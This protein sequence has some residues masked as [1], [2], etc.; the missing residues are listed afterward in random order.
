MNETSVTF[1]ELKEVFRKN[2]ARIVKAAFFSGLLVLFLSFLKEPVY[3]AT[4]TFKQAISLRAQNAS[5]VQSF[6]HEFE[7]KGEEP[8]AVPLM[9]SRRLIGPLVEEMGFQMKVVDSPFENYLC[10]M[11]RNIK[12]ELNCFL[13]DK[14]RFIFRNV[15]Y[16][17]ARKCILYLH[18]NDANSFEVLDAQEAFIATG[19]LNEAL[20]LPSVSFTLEKVPSTLSF[21]QNYRVVISPWLKVVDQLI[22]NISISPHKAD[23]KVLLLSYK[24][25][26]RYLAADLLNRIMA[27]YKMLLQRDNEEVVSLQLAYLEKRQKELMKKIDHLLEEEA[28]QLRKNLGN[29][30]FISLSQEVEILSVPKEE[31][32]SRLLNIDLEL[33]KKE[34]KIPF[35]KMSSGVGLVNVKAPFRSTSKAICPEF[36]GINLE[37][38]E[39]LSLHYNSELDALQAVQKELSFVRQQMKSP[40][41][42]ISSLSSVLRDAISQSMIAKASELSLA[43]RDE[44]NRFS[45]EQERLQE[46]LM[47]Q[48]EALFHHLNQTYEHNRLKAKLLEE[49]ISALQKTSI[50]LMKNEKKLILAKLAEIDGRFSSF[51]EKWRLENQLKV[52]TELMKGV[53]EEVTELVEAKHVDLHLQH[54]ASQSLDR[55]YPPID[56]EYPYL[57]FYCVT[58]ALFAGFFTFLIYLRRA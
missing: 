30:G 37:I 28:V 16:D 5:L 36:E 23:K 14:E 53:I 49:K 8:L 41:F 33:K 31:Y 54:I 19:R 6:F 11:G 32:L 43:L 52:K 44:N 12:A 39:K 57:I 45:K 38:A 29:E 2:K 18:F 26:D 25:K 7:L 50:E 17:E 21:T 20:V 48:K 4:A 10:S 56:P 3:K 55:A 47:T 13:S 40:E 27:S 35:E 46:A 24:H 34:K 22:Q 51:P 9:Q 58:A 1:Q 42:E 15:H